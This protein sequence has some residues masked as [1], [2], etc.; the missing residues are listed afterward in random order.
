MLYITSPPADSCDAISFVVIPLFCT[1]LVLTEAVGD[2]DD[3]LPL[4]LDELEAVLDLDVLED[5]PL[6]DAEL[7]EP[8]EPVLPVG[9][10][11]CVPSL[12]PAPPLGAAVA[13][14]SAGDCSG[15]GTALAV[16]DADGSAART[17]G[18]GVSMTELLF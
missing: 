1:F 18:A 7:D 2:E 5:A 17:V 13:I 3:V 6:E 15:V 16:G 12:L 8:P 4:D 9:V 14:E 10:H 11:D